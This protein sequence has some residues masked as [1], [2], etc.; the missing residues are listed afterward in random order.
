MIRLETAMVGAVAD[1]QEEGSAKGGNSPEEMGAENSTDDEEEDN[2]NDEEGNVDTSRQ[3]ED[4]DNGGESNE[5]DNDSNNGNTGDTEGNS[6]DGRFSDGEDAEYPHDSDKE[7]RIPGRTFNFISLLSNGIGLDEEEE[8]EE[9][10]LEVSFEEGSSHTLT[11]DDSPGNHEENESDHG[12]KGRDEKAMI[13]GAMKTSYR[14]WVFSIVGN[15]QQLSH[16]SS[17]NVSGSRDAYPLSAKKYPGAPIYKPQ[18]TA[19]QNSH[20]LRISNLC[21]L[22]NPKISPTEANRFS[23][24]R[25]F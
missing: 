23:K 20:Q 12:D 5:G 6:Q 24:N 4:S 14:T 16:P 19:L 2:S 15:I 7:N 17:R 3:E 11:H 18:Q 21:H 10:E 1:A 22:Q 9:E 25:L 8:R 13:T